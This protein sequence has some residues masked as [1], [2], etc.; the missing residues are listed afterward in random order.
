[1]HVTHVAARIWNRFGQS[2]AFHLSHQV[3]LRFSVLF[4][5]NQWISVRLLVFGV[6]IALV[7][8]SLLKELRLKV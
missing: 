1:M 2:F 4:F 3:P 7:L 8:V 5:F 6:S